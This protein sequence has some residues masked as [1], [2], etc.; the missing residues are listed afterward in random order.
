M[1]QLLYSYTNNCT[2]RY[3]YAFNGKE[4]HTHI[5]WID[6]GA[7]FYNPALGRWHNVDAM[8]ETYHT[9]SPYHFSGNNPLFFIE[10]NGMDY[11]WGGVTPDAQGTGGGK[12][13]EYAYL[14]TNIEYSEKNDAFYI[15]SINE[16]YAD[17]SVYGTKVKNGASKNDSPFSQ[18]QIDAFNKLDPTDMQNY[19]M[20]NADG[21]GSASNS[22]GGWTDSYVEHSSNILFGEN[23]LGMMTSGAASATAREL[24]N[25]KYIV[26]GQNLVMQSTQMAKFAARVN[27]V[28]GVIGVADNSIQ[29]YH[30]FSNGNYVRGSVQA[31]QAGLYATG[32]VFM[33]IPGG[34]L[35]GGALILGAGVSDLVEYMIEED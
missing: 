22:G 23:I 15:T 29:A 34:Q 13:D 16:N 17:K 3:R 26:K 8:A 19:G 30:D 6:Y 4:F 25:A 18:E 33:A 24:Q 35:I 2:E 1:P 10:K 31:S 14:I 20:K 21:K 27:V 32:L 11:G 9:Q 28:G 5:N 12:G 7:R